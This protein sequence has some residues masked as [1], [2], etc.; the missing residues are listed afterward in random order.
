MNK[1]AISSIIVFRSTCFAQLY[2]DQDEVFL[3]S[4]GT[5]SDTCNCIVRE[6]VYLDFNFRVRTFGPLVDVPSAHAVIF[7]RIFSITAMLSC[8]NL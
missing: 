7:M 2:L 4:N 3:S 1:S 5:S 6:F 8:Q